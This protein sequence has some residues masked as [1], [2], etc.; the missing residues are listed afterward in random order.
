MSELPLLP[1]IRIEPEAEAYAR[2]K[3]AG[4]AFRHMLAVVPHLFPTFRSLHVWLEP[5]V[6]IEDYFF[7]IWEVK[8][9]AAEYMA[10]IEA[11]REWGR[12][13]IAAHR[14]PVWVTFP[15]WVEV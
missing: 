3:G 11:K 8:V 15:L 14:P 13:F 6:S 2:E 5:D 10:A 9:P 7:I 12:M 1:S 4:D